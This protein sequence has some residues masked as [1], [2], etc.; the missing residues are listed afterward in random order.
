I[1]YRGES[2]PSITSVTYDLTKDQYYQGTSNSGFFNFDVKNFGT[3]PLLDTGGLTDPNGVTYTP[4][5]GQP[6]SV[7]FNFRNG[8]FRAGNSFGFGLDAEWIDGPGVSGVGKSSGLDFG[9]AAIP[10]TITFSNGGSVTANFAPDSS[11]GS[12]GSSLSIAAP[13]TVPLPGAV[14]LFG[15]G[16]VGLAGLA[17]RRK[18]A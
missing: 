12:Y 1:T 9:N 14:W 16:L 2:G 7:T 11:L 18:A 6:S 17:R 3:S 10:L 15:S 13:A 8:A 5:T 4:Q